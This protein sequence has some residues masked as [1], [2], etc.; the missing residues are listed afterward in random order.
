MDI[1]MCVSTRRPDIEI[2][3]CARGITVEFNVGGLYILNKGDFFARKGVADLQ[4]LRRV[5]YFYFSRSI[6]E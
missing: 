1:E 4:I 2:C 5:Q 3:F 6:K